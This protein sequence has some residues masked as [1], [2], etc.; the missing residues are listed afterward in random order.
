[1]GVWLSGN[2]ERRERGM[3]I[4]EG[5]VLW[6]QDRQHGKRDGEGGSRVKARIEVEKHENDEA[7]YHSL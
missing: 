4:G 3:G 5:G 7:V 1:M 2:Q 6:K